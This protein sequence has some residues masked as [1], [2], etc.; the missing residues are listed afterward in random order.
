MALNAKKKN[1]GIRITGGR[2]TFRHCGQGRPIMIAEQRSKRN[3][4]LGHSRLEEEY[5]K[6]RR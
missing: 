4:G 2:Q 5:Y 3:E 6:Q 1:K